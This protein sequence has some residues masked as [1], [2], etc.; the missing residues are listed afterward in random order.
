MMLKNTLAL[1]LLL[2]MVIPLAASAED[3]RVRFEGGIGVNPV[4]A[5]PAVNSTGGKLYCT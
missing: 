3:S 5:G 1:A 4:K 2:G